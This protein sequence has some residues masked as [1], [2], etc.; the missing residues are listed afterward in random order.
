MLAVDA[1]RPAPGQRVPQR[2][3]LAGAGKWRSEALLNKSDESQCLA[4]ILLYPVTE[5]FERLRIKL[6]PHL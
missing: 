6:Q 1:P 5:V 2:F 4:T 3:R